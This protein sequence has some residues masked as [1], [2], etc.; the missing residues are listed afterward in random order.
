MKIALLTLLMVVGI[1]RAAIA[2]EA[3]DS[4]IMYLTDMYPICEGD[5]YKICQSVA[6]SEAP[7]P[8]IKRVFV[9]PPTLV[10]EEG[11]QGTLLELSGLSLIP[12]SS[13]NE[14]SPL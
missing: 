9:L 13:S 7:S 14:S 1:E 12:F 3:Q 11:S 10:I 4:R 6:P 5:L 8:A 2:N